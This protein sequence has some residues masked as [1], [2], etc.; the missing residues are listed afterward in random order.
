MAATLLCGPVSAT[1]TTFSPGAIF[2]SKTN[3]S[4]ACTIAGAA[5]PGWTIV[6]AATG[7]HSAHN[8]KATNIARRPNA[9]APVTFVRFIT[10]HLV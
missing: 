7:R 1:P 10:S 4:P 9:F 8:T 3:A 5:R 6:A 2:S